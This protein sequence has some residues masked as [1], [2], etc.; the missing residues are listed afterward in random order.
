MAQSI[1]ERSFSPQL[2]L[3]DLILVITAIESLDNRLITLR[4]RLMG[5]LMSATPQ[6]EPQTPLQENKNPFE[7]AIS[8]LSSEEQSVLKQVFGVD[9]VGTTAE[10]HGEET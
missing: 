6:E 1:G 10:E 8:N 3:S 2:T 4:T 9:P 5:E 7:Q